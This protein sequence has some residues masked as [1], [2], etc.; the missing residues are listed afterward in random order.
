MAVGHIGPLYRC[1]DRGMDSLSRHM[2]NPCI[3]PLIV[4]QM[5]IALASSGDC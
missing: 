4:Q 5:G 2:V 3:R 1:V